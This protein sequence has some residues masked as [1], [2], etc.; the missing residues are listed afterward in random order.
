MAKTDLLIVES[1]LG[2]AENGAVWITDET[3]GPR[4]LPFLCREIAVILPSSR[5]LPTMHD[6]YR[7]LG[8]G[9]IHWG[10]FIGAPSKTADIEQSLVI[11]AHGPE[12]LTLFLMDQKP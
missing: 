12:A 1:G 10:L 5:I 9:P 2:V 6:A 3:A 7:E 11:G 4:A 8:T